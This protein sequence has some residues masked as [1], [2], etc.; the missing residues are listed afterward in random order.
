MGT[1]G[2][3]PSAAAVEELVESFAGELTGARLDAG[4]SLVRQGVNSIALI[5]LIARLEDAFAVEL[6]LGEILKEPTLA[7]IATAVVAGL[8]TKVAP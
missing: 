5:R 6:D 8:D 1:V 3:T 7:H 2:T 4:S